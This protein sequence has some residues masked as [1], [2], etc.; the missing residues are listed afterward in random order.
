[1]LK[2]IRR[3]GF[4]CVCG[5]DSINE[6]PQILVATFH[7]VV[8]TFDCMHRLAPVVQAA[9]KS[10]KKPSIVVDECHQLLQDKQ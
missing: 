10:N 3:D 6:E 2:D 9:V 7:A 5:S 8:C 4:M 1:M